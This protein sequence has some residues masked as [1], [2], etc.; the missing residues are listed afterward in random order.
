MSNLISDLKYALRNLYNSPGFVAVAIITLALGIGLNCAI[1]SVV[2]M[3][4]FRSL[5]YDISGE[6]VAMY[7]LNLETGQTRNWSYPH[8]ED[9]RDQADGFAHIV[10]WNSIDVS[11]G[12][13]DASEMR[14]GEIVSGD[15]F[16]ALGTKPLLGRFLTLEDDKTPRAHPVTVIS[17][18]YWESKLGGDPDIVGKTLAINGDDYTIIG[19]AH[20]KFTGIQSLVQ[21]VLWAPMMMEPLLKPKSEALNQRGS[22]WLNA[23]GVLKPE[24]SLEQANAQLDL[25]ATQLR[26]TEDPYNKNQHAQAYPWLGMTPDPNQR[27]EMLMFSALVM[28]M[29]GL[30]LLITCANIANLLLARSMS[31]RKEIGIRLALGSTR[32]RI[33]RQLL[34]ESLIVS[35]GGGFIGLLV[36][37]WAVNSIKFLLPQLPMSIDLALEF[38]LDLNILIFAVGLSALTGIVFG[39]VPALQAVKA[40]LIPALKD[41]NVGGHYKRSRLRS[42]LVVGQVSISLVLLIISGLFVRSLIEAKSID[43]GFEHESTLS[44]MLD[45]DRH[46]YTSETGQAFCHDLLERVRELPGV[47]SAC[48]DRCPPLSFNNMSSGYHVEGDIDT[49]LDGAI[50]N[51]VVR[52]SFISTDDFKT[53]GIPIL[54]GRDFT[55]QDMS[56]DTQKIIVNQTF[57]EETWPNENPLGKRLSF[58]SPQGP[59]LEVIGVVK[60]VIYRSIGEAPTPSVYR[61][62]PQRWTPN[63]VLL[64]RVAGNGDPMNLMPVVRDVLRD[65]DP[66]FSP[67]DARSYTNVINFALLPAKAGAALF[68]LF[69]VL[70]LLLAS[71]GLYGVMAYMVSQ[72]THEIGIRMAIGANK[73]DV[74]KLILHQGLKLTSIGLGIGLLLSLAVTRVLEVML[75]EVSPSD[76]LTFVGITALL[77][78]VA[79]IAILIPARRAMKVDPMVALRYE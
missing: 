29:V 32:M 49:D 55:E 17:A 40:D 52:T 15:Y 41:E 5:P 2:N 77:I 66:N 28:T 7:R 9:Y 45:L 30:I 56:E 16:E 60:T 65:M 74:L 20:Y 21:P 73:T 31:R 75:Y 4:L 25:I 19:V 46:G 59:Y 44:M 26:E 33:V 47:E 63:L 51:R 35:L 67:S 22:S 6:V 12:R 23:F 61:A 68:T 54:M 78:L 72:R 14:V 42:L 37:V 39:L 36:G 76:P 71:V 43:P 27:P 24:V 38:G 1:F 8:F 69:G 11:L 64:T 34:L 58:E 48:L 50:Q 3:M 70:A 13:G 53:L 57:A 10:A 79:A 18:M 62:L